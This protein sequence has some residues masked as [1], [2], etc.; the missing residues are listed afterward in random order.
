MAYSHEV[1]HSVRVRIS[2]AFGLAGIILLPAGALGTKFGLLPNHNLG[3]IIMMLGFLAA[4]VPVALFIGFA[5]HPGYRSE[6][7]G[8][9]S[10]F[11]LGLIPLV[12]AIYLFT[13]SSGAPIIHDISTD[14]DT[15]P[16]FVAALQLRQEGQNSLAWSEEVA[17]L[18]REAYP[19]LAPMESTLN[20]EDARARA[21]QVAADM[22]WE[23][24]DAGGRTGYI[25]AVDTT[26]WFGFKDDVVVRIVENPDGSTI[27]LRSV[28]RVGQG[29]MGTN[30]KRIREFISRFQEN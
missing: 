21:L 18:Q 30:A 23:I 5:W 9:L 25:E 19:E 28:S 22:G 1:E 16:T 20:G 15:P 29:D 2:L 4:L 11:L 8:L 7:S 3:I 17:Q 10:G 27:D 12:V 24:I 13:S 14:R 6:R 26:F